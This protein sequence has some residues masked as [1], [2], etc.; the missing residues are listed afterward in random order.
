MRSNNNKF[1]ARFSRRCKWN[2]MPKQ[3]AA[4]LRESAF[5]TNSAFRNK[6]SNSLSRKQKVCGLLASTKASSD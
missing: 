5:C 2:K 6:N 4:S 3:I 1:R